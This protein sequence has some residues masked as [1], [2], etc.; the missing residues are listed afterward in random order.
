[1]LHNHSDLVV[2]IACE[3][4]EAYEDCL[5]KLLEVCNVAIEVCEALLKTLGV[6]QLNLCLGH[7]T[8]HLK[9]KCRGNQNGKVGLQA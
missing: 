9:S 8:V 7:T 2:G 1:M 4:V 5:A 3:A 6:G